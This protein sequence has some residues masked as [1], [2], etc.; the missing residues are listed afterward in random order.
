[1]NGD[2]VIYIYNIY[3]TQML[4]AYPYDQWIIDSDGENLPAWIKTI[5]LQIYKERI[6]NN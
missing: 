3:Q 2:N 4:T 5:F 6:T 1:M